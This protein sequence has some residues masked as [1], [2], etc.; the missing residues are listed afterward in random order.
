[1]FELLHA[2]DHLSLVTGSKKSGEEAD[3]VHGVPPDPLKQSRGNHEVLREDHFYVPICK[4]G[5]EGGNRLKKK[6]E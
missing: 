4:L 1:M 6:Q 2:T 3:L 5:D